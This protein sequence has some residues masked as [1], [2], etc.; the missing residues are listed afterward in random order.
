MREPQRTMFDSFDRSERVPVARPTGQSA[1]RHNES[2]AMMAHALKI[3]RT[4]PL[5]NVE[6]SELHPGSRLAPAV[7]KLRNGHGFDITG[8]GSVEQ[9]Y[10]L[11]DS[12]A[13]PTLVFVTD[14][15]KQMYYD[16][17]HWR[18]IRGRRLQLDSY[19]CVLCRRVEDLQCHH[20]T[21]N[22]FAERLCELITVCD[23]C[24]ATL[25]DK[26]R[27]K[28]P[29]GM[30]IEHARRLGVEVVFEDWLLPLWR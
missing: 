29:S 17:E 7:E 2:S 10:R 11:K 8:D 18:E 26:S 20:I 12:E 24:H 28:F 25:H 14:E 27:L 22:L 30:L 3:L 19:A 9:P 4:A 15:I 1:R 23:E 21:Y 13:L 5:S 16:S 6:W